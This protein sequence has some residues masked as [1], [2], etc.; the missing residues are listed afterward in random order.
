MSGAVAVT[1]VFSCLALAAPGAQ[2]KGFDTMGGLGGVAQA[3]SPYRFETLTP[4]HPKAGGRWTVV[5]RTDRRSGR[6]SRWW[7]LGGS[8][9]IPAAAY[10]GSSTGLSANGKRLILASFRYAYPRPDRWTTRF[11]ILATGPHPRYRPGTGSTPL[12]RAPAEH[13]VLD[14]DFRVLGLS[15]DGATAYLAENVR[16]GYPGSYAIRAMDTSSGRLLR[17][18]LFDSRRLRLRLEATPI[19]A[20]AAPRRLY[21]LYYGR[22]RTVYL[23]ALDTASGRVV[24]K[25][26]PPLHWFANPMMLKL[27]ADRGR[28]LLVRGRPPELERSTTLMSIETGGFATSTRPALRN[29]VRAASFLAFTKTPRHR[30]GIGLWTGV[31]GR[32][33]NGRPILLRELG[34][35]RHR[36]RVLVFGCIHGDECAAKGLEPLSNGCPDQHANIYLVPNLDPDGLAEATRLNGDGVDLNRNFSVDWRRI[37]KPGDPE[38]SGPQP[39]SEPETRLAERIVRYLRP[40]VTI[41]FHQHAGPHP[42]VRAWG[43]SAPAG[44][45]FAR[46]AGIPFRLMP[47]LDGTAPNWQNRRFPGTSSYV[48]ELPPGQLGPSLRLRL[49]RAI[50]RVGRREAQVGEG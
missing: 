13:F 32:S 14:G 31:V 5:V 33:A 8:W 35:R 46:L 22:G 3:G 9:M 37:G 16:P 45:L 39:F 4:Q 12:S 27:L 20:L 25:A 48:V 47:W 19:T 40:R 17:G 41:W 10:D 7:H 2:A 28:R 26:L 34:D 6:V 29:A 36:G 44:R 11:A 43:A 42:F 1:T 38:Y 50:D 49:E 24:T 21:T 23:Q 30:G 15:P 18:D